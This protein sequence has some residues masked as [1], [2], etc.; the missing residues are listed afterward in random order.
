MTTKQSDEIN[1]D[2]ISI[3]GKHKMSRLKINV[4]INDFG[5][6]TIIKTWD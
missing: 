2:I 3:M 1:E 5:T 6:P 4:E